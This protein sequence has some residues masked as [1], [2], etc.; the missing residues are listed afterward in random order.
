MSHVKKLRS[1]VVRHRAALLDAAARVFAAHGVHASLDL[2]V[3]AAGVGRA[4]L[5][6]HFADRQALLL[7]LVDRTMEPLLKAGEGGP[8]GDVLIARITEL[9]RTVRAATALADAWRAVAPDQTALQQRQRKLL[10]SCR[11]PLADAIAAGNVRP[12]LTLDDV[13]QVMRMVVAANG[14]HQADDDAS[15]RIIDLVVSGMGRRA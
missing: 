6:R 4:T 1:D 10:D 9:G 11:K 2:V 8:P 3:E 12:D 15:R 13:S 5:Y 14:Q 7:A